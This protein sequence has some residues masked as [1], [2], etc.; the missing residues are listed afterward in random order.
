MCRPGPSSPPPAPGADLPARKTVVLLYPDP[1]LLPESIAVE[2]G[3]RSRLRAGRRIGHRTSAPNISISGPL[4]EDSSKRLVTRFLRQKYQ[5][6]KVDLVIPVRVPGPA[7]F[8]AAPCRALSRRARHFLRRES[9]CRQGDRPGAGR[10]RCRAALRVGR[11]ARSRAQGDPGIKQ[12]IVI[13]GTSEIDRDLE[14]AAAGDS[15]S[16]R[17]AG[18]PHVPDGTTDDAAAGL[19]RPLAQGQHGALRLPAS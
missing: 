16:L 6:R 5:G 3:I 12:V 7:I 13:A 19:R 10:H 15:R 4:S 9:G 2:Q 14:A 1:R 17:Q 8:P 11:D 18:R